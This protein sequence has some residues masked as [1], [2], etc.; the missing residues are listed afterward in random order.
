MFA[1]FHLEGTILFTDYKKLSFRL[2]TD[3]L[4]FYKLKIYINKIQFLVGC[5]QI[6]LPFF[7]HA[8]MI[9]EFN[10]VVYF[11]F[12]KPKIVITNVLYLLFAVNF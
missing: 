4:N 9:C 8:I 7:D 1:C 10:G 11:V 6:K 2:I 3:S 5:G 12:N